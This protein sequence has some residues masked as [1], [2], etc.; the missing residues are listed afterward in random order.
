MLG[1]PKCYTRNCTH[2]QGVKSDATD[3]EPEKNERN[4]CDAFPDGIPNE[5]AYGDNPHTGPVEGD[6][7]ITYEVAR[8]A[9]ASD[10][11]E[12]EPGED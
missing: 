2:F 4:V 6:N 1:E 8:H 10:V 9:G 5:I 12:D 3:D 7:G 11:P